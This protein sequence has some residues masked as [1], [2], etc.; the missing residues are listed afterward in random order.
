MGAGPGGANSAA[1]FI[2][3]FIEDGV[4]WCH[5]DIAGASGTPG[6][7]LAGVATTFA[8]IVFLIE[9]AD[10]IRQ[11]NCWR[12]KRV[13]CSDHHRMDP[14]RALLARCSALSL[15][16]TRSAETNGGQMRLSQRI[17]YGIFQCNY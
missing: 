15:C 3:R 10:L 1:A 13:G 16:E 12:R 8:L 2:E 9:P 5:F 11:R 14:E 17:G 6:D 4:Q 7:S